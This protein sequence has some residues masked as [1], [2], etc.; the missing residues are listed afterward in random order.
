MKRIV[1]L[2]LFLGILGACS[3]GVYTSESSSG[4]AYLPCSTLTQKLGGFT[5]VTVFYGTNRVPDTSQPIHPNEPK[6]FVYDLG[7]MYG[8]KVDE[9][10]E[11]R[12][13]SRSLNTAIAKPCHLGEVTIAVPDRRD[14]GKIKKKEA[15]KKISIKN[16][17]KYFWT[18][19]HNPYCSGLLTG[20]DCKENNRTAEE[21]FL[22]RV[23]DEINTKNNNSKGHAFVFVH[24]FNVP[25]RN[26]AFRSA[27]LK[28]DMQFESPVM[29]Y[30]W[31]ANGFAGDY[32]ND[33]IDADR[34]VD[35]LARFLRLASEAVQC[36]SRSEDPD[37]CPEGKTKLHIIAHSMGSRVTAKALAELADDDI[38]SPEFG[39]IFF[40][41]GDIDSK[42]FEKWMMP[43]LPNV[44]GVTIYSSKYDIPLEISENLRNFLKSFSATGEDSKRRIGFIPKRE[45]PYKFERTGIKKIQTVNISD[46]GENPAFDYVD[47]RKW[48]VGFFNR[49][50]SDYAENREVTDDILSAICLGGSQ[51]RQDPRYY[52]VKSS[53]EI[54]LK[55]HEYPPARFPIVDGCR[56]IRKN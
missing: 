48:M 37:K 27:Q 15:G 51:R 12:E 36:P 11:R 25:F 17:N 22:L 49:S 46:V 3:T 5:C 33:Q 29:F 2:A 53:K 19:L 42:L 24:G 30:S 7:E 21:L 54:V 47:P 31:P 9:E 13:P 20:F 40:A 50:H 10:C 35:D 44:D 52:E 55:A 39:Q 45:S 16:A 8:I 26:A 1:F 32:L 41:A 4:E 43:I 23:R 28:Y 34:S 18:A 56:S 14:G 38:P 6:R